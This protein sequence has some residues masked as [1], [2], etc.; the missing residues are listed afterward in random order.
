MAN[1]RKAFIF[2]NCDANKSEASMNIFYNN[3]VYK[4]TKLS[5]KNLWKKVKEEYGAERIQIPFDK[6]H[7]VEFQIIEGDPVSASDF[8]QF[9]TIR[10][11]DCY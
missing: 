4:D 10:E 3:A 11:I 5:R 9:G 6:L 2:F 1:P 7:E 8:I